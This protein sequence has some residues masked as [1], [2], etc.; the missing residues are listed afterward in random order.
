MSQTTSDPAKTPRKNS[1]SVTDDMTKDVTLFVSDMLSQMESDFQKAGDS[2]RDR[3]REISNKMDGL[4]ESISGLMHD[5][6]LGDGDGEATESGN[7]PTSSPERQ[8]PSNSSPSRT[9]PTTDTV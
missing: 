3:M 1:N 9:A 4:E 7:F 8:P 5:A 6:G 2:I